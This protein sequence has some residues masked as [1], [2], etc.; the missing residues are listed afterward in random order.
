MQEYVPG[1]DS[2]IVVC[3][4][5][6]DKHHDLIGHFTGRK[7]RQTPA[8]T[9][10]GSVVE[11]TDVEPVITPSIRLLR[12]FG[13]SGLAEIEYKHDKATDTYMLI[14]INPRHWDQHELGTLVGVNLSWLAYADMVGPTQ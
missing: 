9:G 13:Y 3:C 10:T 4:C 6:M 14:E 8:L 7:L 5:Y 2:E 11:A 1:E 12:A